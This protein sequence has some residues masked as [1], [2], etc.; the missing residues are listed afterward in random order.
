[1]NFR[2]KPEFYSVAVV[3]DETNK[4]ETPERKKRR[5]EARKLR[6]EEDLRKIQEENERVEA[7]IKILQLKGGKK[8]DSTETNMAAEKI[9]PKK[10][11]DRDDNDHDDD[12]AV[13]KVCV[14]DKLGVRP[15]KAEEK[16]LEKE[17]G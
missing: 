14:P 8:S 15:E 5:M 2:E 10:D 11:P 16:D 1:M 4:K 17:H 6:D 3:R 7:A 9:V 12:K 13:Q